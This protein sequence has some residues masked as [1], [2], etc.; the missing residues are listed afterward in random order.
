MK[1]LLI[2]LMLAGGMIVRTALAVIDAKRG[3]N[4]G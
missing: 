3:N 4:P 2:G 1:E